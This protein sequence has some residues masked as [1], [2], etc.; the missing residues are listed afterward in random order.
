MDLKVTM[1][2]D[3][4]TM[5]TTDQRIVLQEET[6]GDLVLNITDQAAM[7]LMTHEE[8][9]HFDVQA[10]YMTANV[11]KTVDYDWQPPVS[12]LGIGQPY[13]QYSPQ[14]IIVPFQFDTSAPVTGNQMTFASTMAVNDT[15]SGSGSTTIMAN[16]S[17]Y[18]AL[19]IPVSS[20]T[21]TYLQ[22]NSATLTFKITMTSNGLTGTQTVQYQWSP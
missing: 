5:A 17:N 2:N 10:G 6:Y 8:H 7:E 11:T 3:S 13:L 15:P 14:A 12:G 19:Q 1:R 4:G 16:P 21:M 9:L 22:T 18:V 20:A